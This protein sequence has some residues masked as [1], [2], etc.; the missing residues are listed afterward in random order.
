MEKM[1]TLTVSGQ[2]YTVCDPEAVSFTQPQLLTT[3]QQQTVWENLGIPS[4]KQLLDKVCIPFKEIGVIVTCQP[5]V[6]YPLEVAADAEAGQ[7]TRCGKNLVDADVLLNQYLIKD[8]N[9]IYRVVESSTSRGSGV[10]RFSTP[11]PANT[12]IHFKFYDFDGYN[13]NSDALLSTSISFGDGTTEAGNWFG[14]SGTFTNELTIKKQKP[15]TAFQFYTYKPSEGFFCQ[16]SALQVEIGEAATEYEPFKLET[17]PV[18]EPIPGWAGVNTIYADKG[19]VT[20]T[21]KADP[22]A[23]IDRLQMRL[24]ALEAAVVNNA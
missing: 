4:E 19:T 2:T 18:G 12:P 16:F 23:V 7:I 21:G 20:V 8:E 13:A 3:Q 11:I 9:G 22:V 17:F 10:V 14:I 15:I 24:A 6:G 1:K 5:V